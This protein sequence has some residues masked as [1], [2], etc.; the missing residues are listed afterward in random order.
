MLSNLQV[1]HTIPQIWIEGTDYYLALASFLKSFSYTDSIG[2]ADDL[3]ITLADRDRRFI[4]DSFPLKAQA[5]LDVWIKVVN[6]RFPTDNFRRDCGLFEIDSVSFSVPLNSV[7]IKATSIPGSKALKNTKKTR[8]FENISFRA[9]AEQIAA[10]HGMSVLWDTKEFPRFKRVEQNDQSDLEFI[11]KLCDDANLMLKIKRRQLIIFA[12]KE[13]ELKEPQYA[14][15]EGLNV[16]DGTFETRLADTA[17][18]AE[19]EFMNPE[20][21]KLSTGKAVDPESTSKDKIRTSKRP[22]AAPDSRYDLLPAPFAGDPLIDYKNDEPAVN[23]GKGTG[24]KSAATKKAESELRKANRNRDVASFA[25]KGQPRINAG[26]PVWI[27]G[28]G[29][30]DGKYLLENVQHS[31]IP[32]Y[33]C[34]VSLHKELKGDY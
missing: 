2:K 14:I 6:W 17:K 19:C 5:E 27:R 16:I 12:E 29:K 13:Y 20:T 9:L 21:G 22:A 1:R 15:V 10:E 30:F 3:T 33:S 4:T 26:E 11:Q 24:L 23:A 31:V 25:L 32:I 28:Y 34:R 8:G 7:S 18:E